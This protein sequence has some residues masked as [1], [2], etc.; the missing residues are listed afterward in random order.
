MN[1]QAPLN[2]EALMAATVAVIS[3]ELDY[4][5]TMSGAE[6]VAKLAV[7]AYLAARPADTVNSA[8]EAFI[9][10]RPGYITALKNTRGEDRQGDYWRWNGHAEARRQFAQSLGWTVPY[11]PGETTR[12]D[13]ES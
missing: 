5:E 12:P 7:S 4:I 10:Q 1:D 3:D 9:N 2:E 11:N 13:A 8:A 6:H